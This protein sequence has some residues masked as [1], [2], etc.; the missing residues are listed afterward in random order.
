VTLVTLRSETSPIKSDIAEIFDQRVTNVTNVTPQPINT[1]SDT[2]VASEKSE[3][4]LQQSKKFVDTDAFLDELCAELSAQQKQPT[5]SKQFA[6]S[7]QS[8]LPEQTT[9]SEQTALFE[10]NT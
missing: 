8:A 6:L 3:R 2:G 1:P 7:E 9:L 5:P 4:D 10:Q